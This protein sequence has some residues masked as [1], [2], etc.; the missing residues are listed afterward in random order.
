MSR[1]FVVILILSLGL[2]STVSLFLSRGTTVPQS[3]KQAAVIDG[4]L[5]DGFC[6]VIAPEKLVSVD[7]R[8]P[9]DMC[10]QVRAGMAGRYV[11]LSAQLPEPDGYVT[12]RSIGRNPHWEEGEDV[13]QVVIRVYNEND[14]MLVVGPRGA[15]SVK[16]RWTG[17]TEWYTSRP[18]KFDRFLVAAANGEKEWTG[19]GAIPLDQLGSPRGGSVRLTAKRIRA[20]RPGRPEERWHWPDREPT[21]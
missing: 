14:W 11:S 18:D 3:Q 10:G 21:A 8:T 17:E 13:L 20:M 15:Y 16:W 12:A 5:S 19:E 4:K 9:P 2:L 6:H 1:L 7:P